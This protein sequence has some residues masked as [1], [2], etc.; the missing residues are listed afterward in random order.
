MILK[1]ILKIGIFD[2]KPSSSS[3]LFSITGAEAVEFGAVFRRDTFFEDYSLKETILSPCMNIGGLS[4][5]F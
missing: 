2:I 3:S 4:V 5:D 1:K